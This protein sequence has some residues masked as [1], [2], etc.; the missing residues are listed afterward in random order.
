VPVHELRTE[1]LLLRQWRHDDREPWA[2]LNADPQVMAH[3]PSTLTREESDQRADANAAALTEHGWGLWAVEVVDEAPFIGFV[4]LAVP[5]FEAPFTPCVEVGWRI[6]REHWG[7]GYAPEAARAVVAFGF[8]VL[9]LDEIVSFTAVGNA[10]SRRVM[11]KLGMTEVGEFDH[12]RLPGHRL[13]R[14][15]LYRLARSIGTSGEV[16]G[17]DAREEVDRRR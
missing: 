5:G 15:V 1:R 11:D 4:G 9:D 13:E 3:F 14:H 12:P 8:D 16:V 2:A 17:A 10:S 6:A 7:R